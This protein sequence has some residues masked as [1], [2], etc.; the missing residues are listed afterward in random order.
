MSIL[1]DVEENVHFHMEP[2][3]YEY[4]TRTG[5]KQMKVIDG[6]ENFSSSGTVLFMPPAD[7]APMEVEGVR[8]WWLRLRFWVICLSEGR[9]ARSIP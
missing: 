1:F 9:P 7:F 3:S 5:F 8:R 2:V 4:S 6:T